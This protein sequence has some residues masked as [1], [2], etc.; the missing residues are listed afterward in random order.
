MQ[1]E[2][3][4]KCPNTCHGSNLACSVAVATYH[5][6][7]VIQVLVVGGEPAHRAVEL[8]GLLPLIHKL[9]FCLA[10]LPLCLRVL[11]P[12]HVENGVSS[13]TTVHL[14]MLVSSKHLPGSAALSLSALT[15]MP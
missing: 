15:G 4:V 9:S 3:D 11:S 7:F 10:Q 5:Q 13:R 1:E 12:L 8:G 6:Q 2:V 14:C